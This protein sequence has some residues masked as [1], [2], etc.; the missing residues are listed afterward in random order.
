MCCKITNMTTKPSRIRVVNEHGEERI[1]YRQLLRS[2][3]LPMHYIVFRTQRYAVFLDEDGGYVIYAAK[4]I[5]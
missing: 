2:V 4:Q 5:L 1:I 3:N